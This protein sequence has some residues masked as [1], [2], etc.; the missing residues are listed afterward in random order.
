MTEK[1]SDEMRGAPVR[2]ISEQGGRMA[3]DKLPAMMHIRE[4]AAECAVGAS[5][6]LADPP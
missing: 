2:P 5:D 4:D 6:T 1:G 3:P